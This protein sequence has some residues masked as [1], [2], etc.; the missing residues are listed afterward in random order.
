MGKKKA[1]VAADSPPPVTSPGEA[2]P[3]PAEQPPSNGEK[4]RPLTSWRL[5][6][7]RT[8]SY[9]LTVWSNLITP[10]EGEPFEQLSFQLTRSFKTD[11]G[12]QK[13]GGMRAHD[14][15]VVT[16]LLQKA[17]SFAL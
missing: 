7:D 14:L 10:K 16:F 6:S 17:H 15:P 4:R 11:D 12:W 5:M 3:A 13:G 1:E 8:T 9:E 2:P